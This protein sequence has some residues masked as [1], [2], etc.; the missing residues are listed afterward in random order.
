MSQLLTSHRHA[1]DCTLCGVFSIPL[2]PALF[3]HPGFPHKEKT[4][5]AVTHTSVR[6]ETRLRLDCN[7][8][9]ADAESNPVRVAETFLYALS[10]VTKKTKTQQQQQEGAT[11]VSR[12]TKNSTQNK[13]NKQTNNGNSDV[14][15]KKQGGS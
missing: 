4:N 14:V 5:N 10:R 9:Q 3:S 12:P 6:H 15:P 2:S 8:E 11:V 13:N 7:R 1:F